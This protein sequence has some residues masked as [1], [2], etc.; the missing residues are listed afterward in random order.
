MA[1]SWAI[2]SYD[3]M[4][5]GSKVDETARL[6]IRNHTAVAMQQNDRFPFAA[7][8]VVEPN[9]VDFEKLA[10]RRIVSLS[11]FRKLTVYESRGHQYA[12]GSKG[13][14]GRAVCPGFLPLDRR[15]SRMKSS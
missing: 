7:V 8:D 5:L 14:C 12:Y 11:S 9:T 13:Y 6:E 4:L 15:A 1:V 3:A 2:K 10:D